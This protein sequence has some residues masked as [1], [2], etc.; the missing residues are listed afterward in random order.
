MIPYRVCE[1]ARS[2][3][4]LRPH[5]LY[6]PRNSPGQSTGVDNLSFSPEDLSNPG[7]EPRSPALQ[8]DSLP[9]EPQGKPIYS[10]MPPIFM[11]TYYNFNWI[12]I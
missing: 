10:I 9:V 5:G 8:V 4:T 7:T 6:S 12:I 2:C 3:P 1:V 11:Y